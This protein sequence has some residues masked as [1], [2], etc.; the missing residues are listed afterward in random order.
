M[1]LIRITILVCV[2]VSLIIGCSK[3]PEPIMLVCEGVETTT[4][5]KNGK[6]FE[7]ETERVKRTFKFF[8]DKRT[9]KTG[10][11]DFDKENLSKFEE[12]NKLVWILSVDNTPEIYEE[13][14]RTIFPRRID[15][16]NSGT[17]VSDTELFSSN[18]ESTEYSDDKKM[19][20][21]KD[22]HVTINRVSGDFREIQLENF[23]SGGSYRVITE[24]NC[25]KVNKKF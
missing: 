7:P 23:K 20:S 14:T 10:R 21:W 17:V 24:G 13:D 1:N 4:G 8:Q 11:L 22:Y 25:V 19:G 9:I 18:R 6:S 2:S 12:K 5:G 16:K 3:K 15:S